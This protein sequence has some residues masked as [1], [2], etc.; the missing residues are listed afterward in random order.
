MIRTQNAFGRRIAYSAPRSRVSPLSPTML[1][2]LLWP[3]SLYSALL[4][5]F[6]P[7]L[8][9]GAAQTF[10]PASI[11]LAVR[12]P[13]LSAWLNSTNDSVPPTQAVPNFWTLSVSP[14]ESR[15]DRSHTHTLQPGEL[16][17]EEQDSSR[18]RDICLA[19]RKRAIPE[20]PQLRKCHQCPSYT[21]TNYIQHGRWSHE[22]YAH[23]PISCRG[24]CWDH[25][26]APG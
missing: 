10:F 17:V 4:F 12:S 6:V 9:Q 2:S 25:G 5:I 7:V 8:A 16:G 3:F 1:P 18:Q 26:P 23:V 24:K 11:P 15:A 14:S 20:L 21:Y 22:R 19:M 13:Y